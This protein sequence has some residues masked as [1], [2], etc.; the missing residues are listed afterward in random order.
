MER[1]QAAEVERPVDHGDVGVGELELAAQQVEHLVGHRG[2]DLEAH[3]APEP[4]ATPQHRRDRFEEV[5][6]FVFDLEVG[7]AGDAEREARQDLHAGEQRVEAR[8]DHLLEQHEALVGQRE[9]ARQQ[10][11]HLH[12]R[13]P[14]FA[15][16]RIAHRHREAQGQV[17]DVGERM[18]GVD[19]EG[20]EHGEDPLGE[21]LV[22]R[23][24]VGGGEVVEGH[25]VDAGL[26]EGGRDLVGEH[27]ILACDERVDPC[28]DGPELVDEVEP[29]GRGG[30]Q[31]GGDL[32]EQACDPNLEELVEVV[33]DD[34]DELGSFEHR[35]LRIFGDGQHSRDVVEE[36]QLTVQEAVGAGGPCGRR[37]ACGLL[38]GACAEGDR[39][40]LRRPPPPAQSPG[41]STG[42][43][44]ADAPG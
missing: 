5:L 20:S 9:E 14:H 28:A 32:L 22:D 1:E 37:V 27:L 40:Y 7:V 41:D 25:E 35:E 21:H 11:R 12:A 31:P 29:V 13:E 23:R 15:V 44:G 10:R 26:G 18:R 19:G 42:T 6:G 33:G 43:C 39:R 24:A 30:A 4:A 3:D 17:R 36:R 34:G 16:G 8:R 38:R 2:V